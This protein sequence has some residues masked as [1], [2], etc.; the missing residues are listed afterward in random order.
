MGLLTG[1]ASRRIVIRV[2]LSGLLFSL[3]LSLVEPAE[4]A[5]AL[6]SIDPAYL[7]LAL[8]LNLVGT[9]VARAWVAYLTTASSGLSLGFAELVRINLIARFYTIALPRGAS[10]AVRWHHYRK[11][12]TGNEA[13]ALLVFENMVSLSTLFL[14]GAL[15]LSFESGKAGGAA[16]ILLPLTWIG[17]VCMVVFLLPFFNRGAAAIFRRI[18]KPVTD[19]PGRIAEVF[20]RLLEAVEAYHAMPVRRVGSIMF[21]SIVGYALFILSAWV[22][23]VG[24]GIDLSLAAIAWVRSVTLL[25]ALLPVTIAGIGL[26]EAM[27]ITLLKDYGVTPSVAFMYAIASFFIQL[28]LGLMGGLLE[29]LRLFSREDSENAVGRKTGGGLE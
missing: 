20:G 15:V 10:S 19:R 7:V 3:C 14:S 16:E 28:V 11:G 5:Q 26:R 18:L 1:V 2:V 23:A 9:V 22:L 25:V 17:T 24:L 13:A 29:L 6:V 8:I 12:G 4:I 21:A 27:F